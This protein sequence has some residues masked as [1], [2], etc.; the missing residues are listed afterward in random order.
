[1]SEPLRITP[2][3]ASASP[4]E[5]R[6]QRRR[7]SLYILVFA[8]LVLTVPE[9]WLR[10]QLPG[11]EQA[12]DQKIR[13]EIQQNGHTRPVLHGKSLAGDGIQAIDQMFLY[14][15]AQLRS[16]GELRSQFDVR[17]PGL[18]ASLS[19]DRKSGQ[20][21]YAL[22]PVTELTPEARRALE[23]LRGILAHMRFEGNPHA[24]DVEPAWDVGAY[25]IFSRLL[26]GY[27][28]HLSQTHQFEGPELFFEV[29]QFSQI[30]QQAD[31]LNVWLIANNLAKLACH[32]LPRTLSADW[33]SPAQLRELL[34]RSQ[35][36]LNERSE[37]ARA[38][39]L[40]MLAGNRHLLD[41]AADAPW[42]R[43]RDD[44]FLKVG[45]S[46]DLA[47]SVPAAM[48]AL[49]W[50]FVPASRN[51]ETQRAELHAALAG[52]E[53]QWLKSLPAWV[54][55][56][57]VTQPFDSR[58]IEQMAWPGVRSVLVRYLEQQTAARAL[59]LHLA[60]ETYRAMHGRYPS[61]LQALVPDILL[62]L[63]ADPWTGKNFAYSRPE[64]HVYWL[65]STGFDG[66]FDDDRINQFD[67]A[68]LVC[69][70]WRDLAFSNQSRPEAGCPPR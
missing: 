10:A 23:S 45:G 5:S 55:S 46:I 48:P 27:A 6:S 60:L 24:F 41:V 4:L 68:Q 61:E 70:S 8:G 21:V 53:F 37:P 44:L 22:A 16:S 57:P 19:K 32:N 31:D 66:K 36:L 54:D 33:L 58:W 11:M 34:R 12:L 35:L 25:P 56:Q 59:H 2:P 43:N 9:L 17:F 26:L 64:P 38:L 39:E 69:T 40:Y 1:M 52:P 50:L 18:K 65:N 62:Q 3:A 20:I 13:Q 51:L 47:Q 67:P 15:H 49:G 29:L 7:L 42:Q 14:D 63:P 28:L 30:L